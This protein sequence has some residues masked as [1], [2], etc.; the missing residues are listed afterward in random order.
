MAG[1]LC[2][3]L[4][5]LFQSLS[6]ERQQH[7]EQL[8]H[9]R[10]AGRGDVVISPGSSDRLIIIKSGQGR[11]Y[12]LSANGE[13]QVQRILKAGD[14]VGETWLL[15][16][17]NQSSYVEMTMASEICVLQRRDFV[18]L[19]RQDNEVAVNLLAGQ[20]AMINRLRRQTQLM[21]LPSIE[22]RVVTYLNFLMNDQGSKEVTLPLKLKD[23]ASYLGTS[24]ETL[25]RQFSQLEDSGQI[26]RHLRSIRILRHINE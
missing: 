18:D 16:A 15:G 13:E 2:V 19:I 7:I 6:I 11:L 4:V 24:P 9:H 3:Q 5:P 1:V 12:Q 21:G 14:Y 23:L 25:S 22:K 17:R 26:T 20:A 8:V 10:H